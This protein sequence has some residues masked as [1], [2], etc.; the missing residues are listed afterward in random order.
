[1]LLFFV[2]LFRLSPLKF[3]FHAVMMIMIGSPNMMMM[4]V[5]MMMMMLTNCLG[6]SGVVVL[7]QVR[8]NG[9]AACRC[10]CMGVC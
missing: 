7:A 5:M 1:M 3:C 8:E 6:G 2:L 9:S 4:M 10:S